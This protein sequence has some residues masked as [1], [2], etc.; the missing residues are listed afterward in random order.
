MIT[1][2]PTGAPTSVWSQPL[3]TPPTPI[4]KEVGCAL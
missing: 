2:L 4:W 1:R 3:T